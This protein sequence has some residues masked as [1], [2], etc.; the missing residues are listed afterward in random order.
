VPA[1]ARELIV[2]VFPAQTIES[3]EP[4]NARPGNETV[5]VEFTDRDPVFAKLDLN[6]VGRIRR[7]IA[8]VRCADSHA[9]VNVP[10]IIAADP[11]AE[12][13]Y[14]I[15]SPLPGELMNGRWTDGDD[16]QA[17]LRAVGET[18]AAVH[19]ARLDDIGPITGWDGRQLQIESM[20]WTETLCSTVRSR[21]DNEFSD[22]F[23]EIPA[24]LLSTIQAINPEVDVDSATLLHGDPSRINIHLEPNGLLD[25]ERALVG[26]PA[27]DLAETIFHHLG[28]PDVDDAERPALREALFDGYR[29][30]RGSLPA[31]FETYEPLYRAIAHL[32]VPQTFEKWAPDVDIPTDE[33]EANVREEAYARMATA[34]DALR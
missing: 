33:L 10:E 31:Q 18:V 15:T 2:D 24:D 1:T 16:R 19:D 6:A 8:A 3:I 29:T 21:V 20:D 30:H 5:R 26:D 22:R 25:W 28:Q 27:F 32:L 13:P 4:Q 17:L 12:A 7:E 11:A 9:S 14:M 34:E 23:S